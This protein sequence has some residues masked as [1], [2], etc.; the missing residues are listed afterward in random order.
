MKLTPE[1]K[2]SLSVYLWGLIC[3]LVSGIAATRVQYGWVTGL[4]LFLLTDKVVMA[5]IKTLPPEI[6]EGQILKKAFWGWLLFWLYFT[7]L[8]YTVMVNFQPEFYSNQSLLYRLTHNG[9]VVG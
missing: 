6:E 2:F 9:T 3:G 7:M 4:V 1:N 5:M 8:S